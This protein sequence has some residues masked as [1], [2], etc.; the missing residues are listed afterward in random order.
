MKTA[1]TPGDGAEPGR[2]LYRGG[3]VIA[4]LALEGRIDTDPDALHVID[5]APTAD[6]LPDPTLRVT[7]E[8]EADSPTQNWAAVLLGF[9]GSRGWVASAS[10][11]PSQLHSLSNLTEDER[12]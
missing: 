12:A 4:D 10:A 3:T 5:D 11:D 2:R 7:T 6:A 1:G 8:A 9:V